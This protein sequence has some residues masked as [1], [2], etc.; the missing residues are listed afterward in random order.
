MTYSWVA[1]RLP[2]EQKHDR[3]FV[4]IF[5]LLL[6]AWSKD[7]KW[8]VF[9]LIVPAFISF[10]F[11]WRANGKKDH[12]LININVTPASE[13]MHF[14]FI[15]ETKAK[16]KHFIRKTYIQYTQKQVLKL[17][18]FRSVECNMN[19]M[20]EQRTDKHKRRR[21]KKTQRLITLLCKRIERTQVLKYYVVAVLVVAAAFLSDSFFSCVLSL[22]FAFATTLPV[23]TLLNCSLY[24]LFA[25]KNTNIYLLVL[26]CSFS[27][28]ICLYVI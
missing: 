13:Y 1:A 21:R 9:L 7:K 27:F 11:H 10:D 22:S 3:T 6:W 25:K 28:W 15:R 19:M 16:Q 8:R 18:D 5:L 12:Y 26:S 23:V 17:T 24:P 14:R 20:I 2:I 4:I